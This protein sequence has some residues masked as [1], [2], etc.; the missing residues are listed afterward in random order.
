[1]SRPNE[2]AGLAVI[3]LLVLLLIM[4]IASACGT[5]RRKQVGYCADVRCGH[6]PAD[7]PRVWKCIE[8]CVQG[9]N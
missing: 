7:D 4:F 8:R 1:M 2:G 9:G 5:P 3:V 6:L